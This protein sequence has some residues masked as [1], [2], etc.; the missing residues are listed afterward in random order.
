MKN[1]LLFVMI[2]FVVTGCSQDPRIGIFPYSKDIGAPKLTGKATF[3][4]KDQSYLLEGGGYNI[5]FDRDEFHY[6]FNEWQ[7][8]F[9]LTA[10]F[11]FIGAGTDPHRKIGLMVRQSEQAD[12]S[13][14]SATLHGDGLTVLQWR[15]AK[16]AEMKDPEDQIFASK[17]HY[18]TL[19]LERKGNLFTMHAALSGGPLEKI[20]SHTMSAFGEKVLLGLFINSHH[21]EVLE[22]AKIWH[23]R[24][25]KP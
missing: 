21:E 22:Q 13:H 23:V 17:S 11:E 1:F 15:R 18:Q 19:Q 16:G 5:W 20:G 4:E 25:E 10:D 7:G 2:W 24:L 12:A 8:D 6:L 14:I 9:I 3:N